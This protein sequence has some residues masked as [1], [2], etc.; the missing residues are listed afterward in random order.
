MEFREHL[1]SVVLWNAAVVCMPE[2]EPPNQ[3]LT[4]CEEEAQ[5]ILNAVRDSDKPSGFPL[6]AVHR[7][8]VK[9]DRA[10]EK[11]WCNIYFL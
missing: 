4:N 5:C 3:Q 1:E 7:L 8:P 2:S 9:I 6:F 11:F 10:H